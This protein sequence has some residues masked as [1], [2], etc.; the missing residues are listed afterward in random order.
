MA[1]PKSLYTWKSR[2]KF[3]LPHCR[4]CQQPL[5][6]TL[7]G[8]LLIAGAFINA[9]LVDVSK[10]LVFV[11]A[12]PCIV[13]TLARMR[14]RRKGR[15]VFSSSCTSSVRVLYGPW[16]SSETLRRWADS[17]L[18]ALVA[19]GPLTRPQADVKRTRW[20]ALWRFRTIL[21]TNGVQGNVGGRAGLLCQGRS[22]YLVAIGTNRSGKTNSCINLYISYVTCH[23]QLKAE[24]SHSV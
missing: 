18:Q 7:F 9:R 12:E 21:S 4:C 24:V 22:G 15:N 13:L 2:V 23:S 10:A 17:G 11:V 16:R 14:W 1:P 6:H 3:S 19:S 8:S 5:T 20:N